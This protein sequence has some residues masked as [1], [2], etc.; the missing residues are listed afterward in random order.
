MRPMSPGRSI[1]PA[2]L[3]LLTQLGGATGAALAAAVPPGTGTPPGAG[4]EQTAGFRVDVQHSGIYPASGPVG[5]WQLAWLAPTGGPVRS[6]PAIASGTVFFGSADGALRAVDSR[7]GRER[8]RFATA[9]PVS[10]SPAVAAGTVFFTSGDRHLYAVDAAS[11]RQRWAFDLGEDLPFLWGWDYFLSSP[12]VDGGRVYVGSGDGHIYAVDA[13]TGRLVWRFKTGGRVRSSP[14]VASGTVYCGSMDGSLYAI[15]AVSGRQ[16][17]K[18]DTEGTTL[19]SAKFRFDRTSVQSSPAIAGRL[20]VFGSRDGHLYAVDRDSGRL[21]WRVDHGTNWVVSSPAVFDGMALVGS[22]DDYLFQAIDLATGKERWQHPTG[23]NVYASPA[24]GGGLVYFGCQDGSFWALDAHT[25]EERWRFHAGDHVFASPALA[26]GV[27]YFGADDGSLYALGTRPP[28][29]APRAA[30]VRRAVFWND[31]A[32][33]RWFRGDTEARDFFA[34]AGYQV[35]NAAELAPFLRERIA[36]RA[37]NVVVFASDVL[38]EE[39][40]PHQEA[41][42]GPAPLLRQYLEAG[43]KAVW[44]G[45]PPLLWDFDAAGQLAGSQKIRVTHLLGVDHSTL[46]QD[47]YGSRLTPDGVR[48]GLRSPW[49]STM[50]VEPQAVTTVLAIEESG[51]AA[52]WVKSYGGPEGTGFVRLWGRE[53]PCL[54]LLSVE[55]VAEHGLD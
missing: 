8:W 24:V 16:R 17:W 10:S 27:L 6:T 31:K 12:A 11:G 41:P 14:A 5:N 13:G 42:D 22:S 35:L 32:A 36:D 7:S 45:A 48:W 53:E 39:V 33:G 44:L 30:R 9:G 51:K 3:W 19:D 18:F 34:G 25:G 15:E 55:L 21:A 4:G 29:A 2:C 40:A 20:V 43:G 47:M 26:D 37:P 50:G 23:S 49:L 28:A 52:A 54:D 1:A 38:P 46:H